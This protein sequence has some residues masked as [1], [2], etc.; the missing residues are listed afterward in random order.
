MVQWDFTASPV[1]WTFRQDRSF[2]SFILGPVGSGKS[3]PLLQRI[4]EIGKEQAPSPDGIRRSRF[5]VIRNTMPELRAT[6]AITYGQIYPAYYY[7]DIVWRSPATHMIAPRDS[8]LEIEVNL[9]ALDKPKDV[10]KLLSL[11]LTG[12]AFNEVREVPRTVVS[13]MTERVGRYL[14][15]ERE[16]TWSGIFGDSNPPDTD[17]WL[18]EWHHVKT[19][20]GYRFFQQPPGVV[21]VQRINGG[22][23]IIDEHFPALQGRK[24]NRA[25]VMIWK[26]GRAR[27]VDCPVEVMESA[28][29]YWIVNPFMENMIALSRVNAGANPLGALSY[30]GRALAGKT[31]SEIRSYLQGIYTFVSDGRRVVPQYN[32]EAHGRDNLP[33]LDDQPILIGADIGGGTLQPSA[34]LF[35]KHPRGTYLLH[36]EVVCDDM[37]VKRF[38]ELLRDRLQRR[39]PRHVERRLVGDGWG[40]PAGGKRDE[41]FETR[42]FDFLRNEFGINLQPA[43]TQDIK[44]RV[45]A[46]AA[47]CERMIDGVPG[48]LL[49]RAGC[50]MLRKGLMGAWH[51]KR[52]QVTGEDRYTDTPSKND[53]SHP[54]DGLGYG[55]LGAG[56]FVTLGGTSK[57]QV[58]AM[59][60]GGFEVFG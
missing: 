36:D 35:Q 42:S 12:A 46:I 32:D 49:N 16:T 47:P 13:R 52:L 5:A 7:G 31:L 4:Y 56:E 54:C 10:K 44:L 58:P 28:G 24:L 55:L 6:T 48:I 19:P 1:A 26:R 3:V 2:A 20:E 25:E 34:I 14:L 60:D 23:E 45:A 39:F 29:R 53:A 22:V 33:V 18:Y 21:E 11:E 37:G 15:N 8:G 30:Y 59:A 50:P 27:R 51:Y 40:D 17:H 43:P 38:G 9:I 57:A 41:I